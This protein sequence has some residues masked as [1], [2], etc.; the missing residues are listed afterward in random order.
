MQLKVLVLQVSSDWHLP[1]SE[2]ITSPFEQKFQPVNYLMLFPKYHTSL[3][4]T[5]QSLHG[6]AC[7]AE[8]VCTEKCM[9]KLS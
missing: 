2:E 5:S 3:Q 6:I 4:A 1:F 8:P 9:F 7:G